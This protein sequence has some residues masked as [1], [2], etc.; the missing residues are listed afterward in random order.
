[1]P[2]APNKGPLVATSCQGVHD[3]QA[4][5][6]GRGPRVVDE[7]QGPAPG[8]LDRP[9]PEIGGLRGTE[10][11]RPSPVLQLLLLDEVTHPGF[12]LALEPDRLVEVVLY[13]IGVLARGG[14]DQLRRHRNRG[15]G[16]VIRV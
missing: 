1:M 7:V 9:R 11:P 13:L 8:E 16:E 15:A 14:I 5:A 4:K 12:R 2:G 10:L 6:G 3:A